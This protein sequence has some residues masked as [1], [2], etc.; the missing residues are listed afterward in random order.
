MPQLIII[1]YLS[2]VQKRRSVVCPARQ[3]SK[4]FVPVPQFQSYST[5]AVSDLFFPCP[6]PGENQS[7]MTTVDASA[8]LRFSTGPGILFCERPIALSWSS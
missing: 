4:Y 3:Q 5:Y 2:L 6:H 7:F 8:F 1:A